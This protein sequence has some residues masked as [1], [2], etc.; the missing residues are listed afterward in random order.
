MMAT[1]SPEKDGFVAEARRYTMNFDE[2]ELIAELF[3][4]MQKVQNLEKDGEAEAFI[5]QSM[6]GNAD[7]PYLLVQS[8]L[9]QEVAL[10]EAGARI[11]ELESQ[12]KNAGQSGGPVSGARASAGFSG[13][14]AT[15]PSTGQPAAWEAPNNGSASANT[16]GA[17]A[18][19]APAAK[20]QAA[21]SSSVPMTG[22]SNA[23]AVPPSVNQANAGEQRQQRQ[24][25]GFMQQAMSTAAGVAGGM[26]LANSIGSLFGGGSSSASSSSPST[27]TAATPPATQ[28]D[29]SAQTPATETASA[30]DNSA[31]AEQ[32]AADPSAGGTDTGD[33]QNAS[34]EDDWGGDSG[35]GGFGDFGDDFE[36]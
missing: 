20:S 25:G 3:D 27:A 35:W 6:R 23:T 31:A 13:A 8:V 21:A 29:T 17:S 15:K 5:H 36:L 24:G 9:A 12:L 26:L 2:R 28:N 10:Q 32:A 4:R 7:S 16:G 11:E 18:W 14:A 1:T 30:A 34:H 22:R 19:G 33:L